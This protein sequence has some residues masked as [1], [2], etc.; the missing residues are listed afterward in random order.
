MKNTADCFYIQCLSN[1]L[2]TIFL[3]YFRN[4]CKIFCFVLTFIRFWKIVLEPTFL[5]SYLN[6][7]FY[8]Y[9]WKVYIFGIFYGVFIEYTRLES[10]H[11]IEYSMVGAEPTGRGLSPS[12]SMLTPY[13]LTHKHNNMEGVWSGAQTEPKVHLYLLISSSNCFKPAPMA[14]FPPLTTSLWTKYVHMQLRENEG[15]KRQTLLFSYMLLGQSVGDPSDFKCHG[16]EHP[17]ERLS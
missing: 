10:P 2:I 16:L 7:L 5:L 3:Y 17:A 12:P 4:N 14:P 1:C 13:S 11:H 8:K 15:L 9:I 6:V